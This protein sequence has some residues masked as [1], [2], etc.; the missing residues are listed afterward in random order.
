MLDTDTRACI[1]LNDILIG[2]GFG[3]FG[4]ELANEPNSAITEPDEA[5]IVK[6]FLPNVVS[7]LIA[8][9]DW[10][11]TDLMKICWSACKDEQTTYS[12]GNSAGLFIQVSRALCRTLY[13]IG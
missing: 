8:F 5:E 3:G 11:I 13:S 12:P 10:M 9:V 6:R 4:H 1:Q 7:T 2:K